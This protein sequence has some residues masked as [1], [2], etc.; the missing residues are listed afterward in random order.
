[1][2]RDVTRWAH[3]EQPVATVHS[4]RLSVPRGRNGRLIRRAVQA[5][6]EPFVDWPSPSDYVVPARPADSLRSVWT[7]VQSSEKPGSGT[8][9]SDGFAPSTGVPE[10]STPRRFSVI[11]SRCISSRSLAKWQATLW[12]LPICSSGGSCRAQM[13]CANAHLVR[14][15]HPDGGLIG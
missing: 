3:L 5:R 14:N 13:S 8:R 4:L 9:S 15:R 11:G 7:S 2:R 10:R 1:M 12:D 6:V